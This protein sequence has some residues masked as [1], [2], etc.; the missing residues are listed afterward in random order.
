MI[1]LQNDA[2]PIKTR[3]IAFFTRDD[4]YGDNE[5]TLYEV[6]ENTYPHPQAPDL[7]VLSDIE[8]NRVKTYHKCSIDAAGPFL[9]KHA[10]ESMGNTLRLEKHAAGKA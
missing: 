10:D 7:A 9:V 8:V 5:I 6:V 2:K 1:I 3:H 4:G